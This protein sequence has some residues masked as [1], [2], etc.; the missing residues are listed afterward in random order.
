[1]GDCCEIDAGNFH[2]ECPILETGR[3]VTVHFAMHIIMHMIWI[4]SAQV[5]IK[6]YSWALI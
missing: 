4:S 1:V 6:L 3:Q 5:N 2:G